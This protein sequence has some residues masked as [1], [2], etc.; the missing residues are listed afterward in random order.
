MYAHSSYQVRTGRLVGG[1]AAAC[2]ILAL[3]V[4]A[5][6]FAA[7]VAVKVGI[8]SQVGGT[9]VGAQ[10]QTN[11]GNGG[12]EAPTANA[13]A[14]VA[15]GDGSGI[16]ANATTNGDA[17]LAG[18]SVNSGGAIG[19]ANVD[20]VANS[21]GPV[22]GAAPSAAGSQKSAALLIKLRCPQ[23]LADPGFYDDGLVRLCKM[24]LNR[25]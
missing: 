25:H 21:E 12:G 22:D 7:D 19:G 5:P 1:L 11:L 9:A 6:A 24:A 3:S 23:I 18:V 15:I 4:A 16:G 14:N 10:V 17:G 20:G 8:G 2:T 13:A